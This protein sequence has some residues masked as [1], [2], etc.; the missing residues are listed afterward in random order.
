VHTYGLSFGVVAC[1]VAVC[2]SVLQYVC[3][4]MLQRFIQYGAVCCSDLFFVDMIY[5]LVMAGVCYTCGMS[6]SVLQCVVAVCCS[7]LQCMAVCCSVLQCVAVCAMCIHAACPVV[8]CSVL[9]QC[10]AVCCSVLQ[11][12]AV[13]CSD[14]DSTVA[15]RCS[16]LQ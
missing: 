12:V 3:C 2:C 15:V 16:T 6:F 14:L 1:V 8:C 10:V 7:V 9:L 13:C 5:F 4:S 11:C